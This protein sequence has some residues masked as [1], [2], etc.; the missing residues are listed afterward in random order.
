MKKQLLLLLCCS[1]FTLYSCEDLFEC[2]INKRPEIHDKTFRDGIVGV[3]YYEEVTTE[4]KNEPRDD[5]YGYFYDI[6]G[7]L[8]EGIQM[9][10]NYRT[11]SFEGTPEIS[12]TFKFT[13]LLYVDPPLN[14]DDDTGEYE[15]VMCSDSTSKEFTITINE[16]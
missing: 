9:F 10:A 1:F 12:G 3:Y 2:V 4:I 14:Y 5:D 8:P 11:V 13:L 16:L 15:S 7:D 6:Y